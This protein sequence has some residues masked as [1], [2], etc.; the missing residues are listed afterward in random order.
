MSCAFSTDVLNYIPY[1]PRDG[2][3]F[4]LCVELQSLLV[5]IIFR[6]STSENVVN[7]L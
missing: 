2:F 4:S 5:L 6:F 1:I 3:V 7:S